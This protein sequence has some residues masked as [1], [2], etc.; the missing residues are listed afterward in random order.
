MDFKP[1]GPGKNWEMMLGYC[2]K[3]AGKQHFRTFLHNVTEA[4][5]ALPWERQS[6]TVCAAATRMLSA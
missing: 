5:I 2:T 4:Q 6:G 1:Y 3:D